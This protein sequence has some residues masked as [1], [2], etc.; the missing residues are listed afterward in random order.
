LAV[1]VDLP[2]I[3]ARRKQVPG[4]ASQQCR[5]GHAPVTM[6]AERRAKAASAI[7]WRLDLALALKQLPSGS[8][9][10]VRDASGREWSISPASQI[11]SSQLRKAALVSGGQGRDPLD[12]GHQAR[13]RMASFDM[14][15]RYYWP[16]LAL[17]FHEAWLLSG[18]PK[19]K[20]APEL[21]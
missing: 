8:C 2:V 16:R 5:T 20:N 14:F 3:Q 21:G 17:V 19:R 13:M 6:L 9:L 15:F 18:A 12:R 10:V 11:G 1:V 7:E 4:H